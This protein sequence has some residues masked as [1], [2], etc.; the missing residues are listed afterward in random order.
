MRKLLCG[1]S[2]AH[3]CAPQGT[4][5]SNQD[6]GVSRKEI[7]SIDLSAPETQSRFVIKC[8]VQ[9]YHSRYCTSNCKYCNQYVHSKKNNALF[10]SFHCFMKLFEYIVGFVLIKVMK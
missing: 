10:S 1:R 5:E 3:K 6:F 7:R 4:R 9:M 2:D 8:H